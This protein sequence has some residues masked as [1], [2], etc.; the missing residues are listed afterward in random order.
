MYA[1]TAR[2][3]LVTV[4]R[5]LRRRRVPPSCSA[6]AFLRRC[7]R[8]RCATRNIHG[9][10]GVLRDDSF[11][12]GSLIDRVEKIIVGGVDEGRMEERNVDAAESLFPKYPRT[13][14]AL[15]TTRHGRSVSVYIPYN[16]PVMDV[17]DQVGERARARILP[18]RIS[19]PRRRQRVRP[20][21]CAIF[22]FRVVPT[23]FFSVRVPRRY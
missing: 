2:T 21:F 16:K 5:P 9:V 19:F 10:H 11:A 17:H 1:P 15:K 13:Y 12:D 23:A 18:R 4:R 3:V 20:N 8:A 14:A 22:S 6:S 7:V